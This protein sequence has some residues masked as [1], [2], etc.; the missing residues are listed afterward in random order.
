MLVKSTMFKGHCSGCHTNAARIRGAVEVGIDEDS[1][2]ENAMG[3]FRC[4]KCASALARRLT[5]AVADCR[6]KMARGLVY[7]SGRWQKAK[8]VTRTSAQT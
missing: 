3:E 5:A 4:L 1:R 8:A 7:R 6:A 2:D